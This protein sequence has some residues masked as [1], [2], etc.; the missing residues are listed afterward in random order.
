VGDFFEEYLNSELNCTAVNSKYYCFVNNH[1]L[2]IR[3]VE[4]IKNL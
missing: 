3:L 2:L 4:T 1:C